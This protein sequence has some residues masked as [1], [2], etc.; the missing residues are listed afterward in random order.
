VEGDVTI[1]PV[2]EEIL[3]LEKQL[4]LREEVHV[5]RRTSIETVQMPITLKK[6]RAIV[7]REPTQDPKDNGED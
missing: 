1:I 2:I 3:K 5:R 6:Q 4:I 7:S